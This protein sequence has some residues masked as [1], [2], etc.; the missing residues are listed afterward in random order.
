MVVVIDHDG[1]LDAVSPRLRAISGCGE[2]APGSLPLEAIMGADSVARVR[3]ALTGEPAPCR[4][5][6]SIGSHEEPDSESGTELVPTADGGA[7]LLVSP[8]PDAWTEED[9][10]LLLDRSPDLIFSLRLLPAISIR[11]LNAASAVVL[12]Y[13]PE[14]VRAEPSLLLDAVHPDDRARIEAVF[15]DPNASAAPIRF[16]FR[17][18]S[19]AWRWLELSVTPVLDEAGRVAVIDG[20]A[21]DVTRRR[22]LEEQ[23]RLL[24]ER[25]PEMIYRIRVSPS[26]GMDYVSSACEAVTGQPPDAYYRDPN[27]GFRHL[28]PED[29]PLLDDLLVHP[30]RYC[31]QPLLFRFY[32]PE[33]RICWTEWINVPVYDGQ[34]RLIAIE[35]VS[36]DVTERRASEEALRIANQKLN[37]LSSVTRHDTLNQLTVLMGALELAGASRD[38]TDLGWF[39]ARARTATDTIRRLIEFTRDYQEIGQGPPRWV[40]VTSTLRRAVESFR[41]GEV[42]VSIPESEMEVLAD[43]MIEKV[44]FTLIENALRH[45]PPLTEIRFQVETVPDGSLRIIC[46]DD[47]VGIPMPEKSLIFE[48]GRGRN[49]GFGLY[50]ARE[51]LSITSMSIRETSEPGKG[52]RFE[53]AVPASAC[54][55]SSGHTPSPVEGRSR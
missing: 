53:I 20:I 11:Y 35:G 17:H 51:I 1:H 28:H 37:L 27:L 46:E 52:A 33:G 44:F 7:V 41:D 48:R 22:R 26:Y 31:N 49:T 43:A 14:E 40:S 3:E 23:F 4:L 36:R 21:R 12:G 16:R 29:R 32:R 10:A 38:S 39:L 54:R 5:S 15:R 2:S 19:G 9:A 34:D 55:A 50:L 45:G 24:A 18:G 30:E 47:G 25:S 13:R 6:L 8:P 42:T